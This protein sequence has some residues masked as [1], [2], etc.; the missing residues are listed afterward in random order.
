M[1]RVTLG[2]VSVVGPIS[3][4]GRA[5]LIAPRPPGLF[6]SVEQK[7]VPRGLRDWSIQAPHL[8]RQR[9]PTVGR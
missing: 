1:R 8:H 9:L 6:M 2:I 4:A 3:Q 7:R 5:E